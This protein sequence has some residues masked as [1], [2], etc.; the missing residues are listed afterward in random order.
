VTTLIF[1]AAIFFA[2]ASGFFFRPLFEFPL[3]SLGIFTMIVGGYGMV[4]SQTHKPGK[5]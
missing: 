1:G 3:L 2:F 5:W 4:Y